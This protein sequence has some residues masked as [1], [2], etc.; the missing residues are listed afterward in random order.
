MVISMVFVDDYIN[1]Y[2]LGRD[3][4]YAIPKLG[5]VLYNYDRLKD[6]RRK[7]SYFMR[8]TGRRYYYFTDSPVASA[9]VGLSYDL[10]QATPMMSFGS[11]TFRWFL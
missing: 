7:E 2:K 5:P 6:A 3:N 8:N 11:N 9:S 10:E 1:L 4:K